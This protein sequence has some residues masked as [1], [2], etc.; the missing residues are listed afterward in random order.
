MFRGGCF[1]FFFTLPVWALL[2]A[3]MGTK[4]TEKFFSEISMFFSTVNYPTFMEET[5][6]IPRLIY[7]GT[8]TM[9]AQ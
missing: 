4:M 8:I 5:V 3:N 6:K 9:F 2:R 1:Y 7:P